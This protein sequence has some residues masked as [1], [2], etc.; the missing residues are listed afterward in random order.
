MVS[1]H[2]PTR[3]ATYTNGQT[4]SRFTGFNPRT[5]TGCDALRSRT[6]HASRPV[7]IHAPTRGAT[8]LW[9]NDMDKLMFQS[10][11]PHGVRHTEQTSQPQWGEFQSTHPHGVRL[12]IA[13]P[14]V[15]VLYVSIHAPTRGATAAF[16]PH[17]IKPVSFNPRT[18]TGCDLADMGSLR[19]CNSFNPRTHT[20]CD[21][22]A[23]QLCK[24]TKFQ[25][26]HPH[27]V[28]RNAA[29]CLEWGRCFNPRTHTGCDI[30]S[31]APSYN[32]GMFQSTHPHGVRQ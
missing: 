17:C 21:P 11:H 15:I 18:H 2:A 30:S 1:I 4:S 27:G 5:H 25:S 12:Y 23:Q 10:T 26:T 24:R 14:I 31:F 32:S 28:R 13:T 19:R 6:W 8:W 22:M 20:G 29:A 7:S 9:Y 3:G 16:K